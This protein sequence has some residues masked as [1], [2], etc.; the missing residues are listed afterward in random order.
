[1]LELLRSTSGGEPTG[2]AVPPGERGGEELNSGWGSFGR[3]AAEMFARSVWKELAEG[4]SPTDGGRR[5]GPP[6]W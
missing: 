6:R 3:W 1:M 4:Y 5:G 2:G